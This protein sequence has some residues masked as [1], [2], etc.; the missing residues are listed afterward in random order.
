MNRDL[1]F[2]LGG[3]FLVVALVISA[4]FLVVYIMYL[5]TL[6]KTLTEVQ[7]HN[8]KMEPGMVWLM[9][10]P[11]FNIYWR[12]HIVQKMGESLRDE[13]KERN[14]PTEEEK[15][16]AKLGVIYA[17]LVLGGIVPVIGGLIALGG[18]VCWIIYWTKIAGFKTQL[19]N[20][21]PG[22]G[23]GSNTYNPGTYSSANPTNQ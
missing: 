16:G 4:I 21:T 19:L 7:P 11:L 5:L 23:G 1:A 14:I 20:N 10:I 3:V 8:R 15:P 18:L 17:S 6:S 13:F 12:F 2:Q 22:T 9:F